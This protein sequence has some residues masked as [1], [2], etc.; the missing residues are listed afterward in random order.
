MTEIRGRISK[1][2]LYLLER[3]YPV[4]LKKIAEETG[5]NIN[6]LRKDLDNI[7]EVLANNGLNLIA[8]PN[9]GI[10]IEGNKLTK[11]KLREEMKRLKGEFVGKEGKIWR[12]AIAFLVREKIPTIEEFSDLLEI[13]RP[14]AVEYIKSVK[15]WLLKKGITVVGKPGSGYQIEGSEEMIRDA[16]VEAIKNFFGTD[17][18]TVA[19][20]FV[21]GKPVQNINGVIDSKNLDIIKSFLDKVQLGIKKEITEE[22]LFEIAIA[23]AVSIR[24]VRKGHTIEFDDK[25]LIEII[26]NPVSKVLANSITTIEE[27]FNVKFNDNEIAYLTSKFLEAKT[28]SLEETETTLVS[29]KFRKISEKIVQ[30]IDELLSIPLNKQDELISMLAHHLERTVEKIKMGIKIENPT[31]ESLKKEYP[32]A[33][34]V[35][36]RVKKLIEEELHINIPEEEVGYIAMYIAASIEK[37]KQP[38]KRKVIVICPMGVVTSKLL[39]YKLTNEIPEIEIVKV[40]SVK[41]LQDSNLTQKIDLVISTVPL[42]GLKIPFVTVS[43]LLR[44]ED[45]K[46]IKE[47]LRLGKGEKLGI[48]NTQTLLNNTLIFPQVGVG[49]LKEVIELLGNALLNSGFVKEGFVEEVL[50]REKKYPTGMSTEIPIAIPHAGPEFTIK[51]GIVIA[52]LKFPL[53]FRDMGDPNKLLDVRIV[54]MPALTGNEEDGREFYEILERLKDRKIAEELVECDSKERIRK[55]IY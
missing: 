8:K 38:T 6:T 10:K 37:I 44:Q 16:I 2:L 54:L 41:D 24:R 31:S 25:K 3:D 52:T 40:G 36:G 15:E 35:A 12:I 5:I 4:P 18:E 42:S 21:Q 9:F 7:R 48:S 27:N 30:L 11:E 50:K 14:T 34:A 23:V 13:S 29:P 39:C 28:Q 33:Y 1:V 22:D 20:E 45:Q 26:Q 32:A 17:Y 53:Q 49:S 47:A 51:K 46:L 55:I 43:P 19:L